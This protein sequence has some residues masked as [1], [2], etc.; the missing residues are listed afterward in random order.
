MS[1]DITI[2]VDVSTGEYIIIAETGN[3]IYKE[4]RYFPEEIPDN[5]LNRLIEGGAYTPY[6]Q[7]EE[8]TPE[9]RDFYG[10]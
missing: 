9:E 3:G 7:E 1:S 8:L 10:V 4:Y 2:D 5:V 6:S